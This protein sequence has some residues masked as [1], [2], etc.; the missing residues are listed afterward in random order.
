[1]VELATDPAVRADLQQLRC[2]ATMFTRPVSETHAMLIAEAERVQPHDRA[3]A[4]AM[5]ATASLACILLGD[6]ERAG[7]LRPTR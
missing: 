5:F 6:F 2:A 7:G 4:A 1:M 3:R